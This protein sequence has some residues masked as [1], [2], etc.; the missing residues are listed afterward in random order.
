M[1][2]FQSLFLFMQRSFWLLFRWDASDQNLWILT[3]EASGPGSGESA[4]SHNR[5]SFRVEICSS[6]SEKI[7]VGSGRSSRNEGG[8]LWRNGPRTSGEPR[9]L[10]ELDPG[11]TFSSCLTAAA[12]QPLLT[13]Q[14]P[15]LSLAADMSFQKAFQSLLSWPPSH[16]KMFSCFSS[17]VPSKEKWA[18]QSSKSFTWDVNETWAACISGTCRRLHHLHHVN[19]HL[20]CHYL[21]ILLL[22]C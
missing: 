22:F 17:S 6:I 13:A 18:G 20:L 3:D 12:K 19:I 1:I 14:T 16:P 7:S 5:I 9:Q 4:G 8:S 15:R 10:T 2:L 21:K 11:V